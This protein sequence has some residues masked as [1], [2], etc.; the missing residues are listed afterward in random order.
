LTHSEHTGAISVTLQTIDGKKLRSVTRTSGILDRVLPIGDPR[1][2]VLRYI[3][4]YGNTIF[5]G[6]QMYPLVEELDRLAEEFSTV[7]E[8]DLLSQVRELAVYCRDHPHI[9]LRFI[10]D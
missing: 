7:E 4:P 1:F 6:E 3:D 8:N 9:F 10:G 2:P 5:N